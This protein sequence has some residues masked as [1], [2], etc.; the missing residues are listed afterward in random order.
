MKSASSMEGQ[1]EKALTF[2]ENGL[3]HGRSSGESGPELATI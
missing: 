2:H 1:H 3:W